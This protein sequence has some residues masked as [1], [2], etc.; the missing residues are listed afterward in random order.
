MPRQKKPTS[1]EKLTEL[2]ARTNEDARLQG[3]NRNFELL[4][5]FNLE[6]GG[7]RFRELVIQPALGADDPAG[8]HCVL[9]INDAVVSIEQAQLIRQVLVNPARITAALHAMRAP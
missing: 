7:R 6:S 5:G 8:R 3:I 9:N 4:L 1:Q 2:V